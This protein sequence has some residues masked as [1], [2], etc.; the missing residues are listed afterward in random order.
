[1]IW[2]ERRDRVALGRLRG[3][4]AP[5]SDEGTHVIELTRSG[6]G[7]RLRCVPLQLKTSSVLLT[8]FFMTETDTFPSMYTGIQ[9]PGGS[10]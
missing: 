6:H 9:V 3:G 1:M 10:Y 5:S 2:K 4:R 7:S 8:R